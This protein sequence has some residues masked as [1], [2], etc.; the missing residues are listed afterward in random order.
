MPEPEPMSP[1]DAA[2]DEQ[3]RDFEV[4]YVR[5]TQIRNAVGSLHIDGEHETPI[6][7]YATTLLQVWLDWMPG[8]YEPE[9]VCLVN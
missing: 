1:Q 9:L 8:E 4:W 5:Q 2:R 7:W 3:A 6:L